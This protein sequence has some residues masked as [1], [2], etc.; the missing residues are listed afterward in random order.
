V[1]LRKRVAGNTHFRLRETED[2]RQ[3]HEEER[4]EYEG[5]KTQKGM[6]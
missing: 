4:I 5:T 2:R 1:F 6:D 3:R